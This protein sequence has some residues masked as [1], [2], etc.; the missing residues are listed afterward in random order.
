[1]LQAGNGETLLNTVTWNIISAKYVFKKWLVR[2]LALLAC[3]VISWWVQNSETQRTYSVLL[4]GEFSTDKI[5]F[6]WTSRKALR[7][8]KNL[9]RNRNGV[10]ERAAN[11]TLH[12]LPGPTSLPGG[13]LP[14]ASGFFSASWACY[15]IPPG[16]PPW[17]TAQSSNLHQ[18][19][20]ISLR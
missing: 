4:P 18:P 13:L 19:P 1:M 15:F 3:E 9:L 17:V 12:S 7:W 16:L 11:D 8:G 6:C 10:E 2:V 20:E 5:E 14:T